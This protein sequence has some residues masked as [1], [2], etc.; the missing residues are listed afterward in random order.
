MATTTFNGAVRSE[1]GFKVISKNATTGAFTEQ[2][3]ST[4]S[5][6]LEIQKVATS[7]RDNIVAAGTTVGANN[8]SLGTAATIFNI[9]PNAHGSGIANAAIN[10]FVTKIGG[11][12]TTTILIDLH[13]GLASGGTADDVIG[14]DGGAAN[15]YIAEL[16][17][18][19]NGI[20]YLI[21]FAC[22]EVPTGGDPDINLVCSATATDAENAAVTSGTVLLNNGDLTLGFYAEADAGA[23]LAALSKKYLYLTS[24]DA[25]EAAYTAGKLVIKIHGAA[26]DYANG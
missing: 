24:G 13:G 1:N 23:T 10:T 20:P 8:A 18:A 12:I 26:F 7:G 15:A 14:T 2:I 17:S 11:D 3:N 25:T 21:E 4:S 5:G 6:V 22:L 9:T 19:V 16:T